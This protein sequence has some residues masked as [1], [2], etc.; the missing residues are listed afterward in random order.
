VVFGKRGIR[1]SMMSESR[2]STQVLSVIIGA[3]LVAAMPCAH[4]ANRERVDSMRPAVLDLPA[5]MSPRCQQGVLLGIAAAG[6]R[7]VAVG[8]RGCIVYSDD[9]GKRWQQAHVP[10]SAT[11][12]AVTFASPT[13]GWAVGHFGVVV[14][15]SDGGVT[16]TTQLD[17]I[18]AAMLRLTQVQLDEAK[19]PKPASVSASPSA[20]VTALEAAK[21]LVDDGPDKPFLSVLFQNVHVG[22]VVGAYGL[23]YRT[24]DGGETWQPWQDHIEN[25]EG[26]HIY[27][28]A[29]AAGRLFLVGEQG[30]FARSDDQGEHF[31]K[32]TTTYA[33]TLFG[34]ETRDGLRVVVYGLR[35]KGSFSADGGQ[36]WERA[37]TGIS[38]AINASVVLND[39]DVAFVSDRGEL[40]ISKDWGRTARTVTV[41][42]PFPFDGVIEAADRTLVAVGTRGVTRLLLSGASY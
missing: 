9:N 5:I 11:L 30:Y 16:W 21:T 14:H 38:G 25:P 20:Q 42:T 6:N 32:K 28:I 40:L 19:K 4:P 39:G 17:G 15:S 7:L 31:I 41:T 23:A 2:W 8:E 12:T 1:G 37:N 10:V 24:I 22:Y 36:T 3:W 27:S 34:I 33:G 18:V 13:Q 29:S 35:G 26:Q